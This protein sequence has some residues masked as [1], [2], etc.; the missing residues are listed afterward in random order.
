M[1]RQS[2]YIAAVLA[3][4]P[5]AYYVLN[6]GSGQPQDSSGNGRHTTGTRT[7]GTPSTSY[8]L[9]GPGDGTTLSMSSQNR[10][11]V[12][13]SPVMTATDNFTVE[14][15]VGVGTQT[16]GEPA[17]PVTANGANGAG[18]T[19]GG[20]ANGYSLGLNASQFV[21]IDL[22][23][24]AGSPGSGSDPSDGTYAAFAAGHGAVRGIS[25]PG[26]GNNVQQWAHILLIR[27]S[28][29]W[30]YWVN[31]HSESPAFGAGFAPNT[32]TAETTIFNGHVSFAVNQF[33]CHVAYYDHALSSA[34]IAAHYNIMAAQ[35]DGDYPFL[36]F[37]HSG[38]GT[39]QSATGRV[40]II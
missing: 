19:P 38:A 18:G 21:S 14:A 26:G 30:E 24:G 12:V 37:V 22:H 10:T 33:V 5:V 23:G 31:T 8:G 13:P 4:A 1:S 11:F 9:G 35:P 36:S 2:D 15:W 3:D 34:R 39:Q 20:G 32:P 29:N 7:T 6:E 28:G 17:V 25:T 27:R 16:G 40:S